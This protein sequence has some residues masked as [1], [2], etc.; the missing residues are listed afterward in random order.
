VIVVIVAAVFR[1]LLAATRRFATF[2]A[3]VPNGVGTHIQVPDWMV[4]VVTV[5]L[6]F[7]P[8]GYL[9]RRLV[10]NHDIQTGTGPECSW[11][12]IVD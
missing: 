2:W 5:N 4:G 12:G 1:L 11:K 3:T 10:L 6:Q 9:L 7:A 8:S